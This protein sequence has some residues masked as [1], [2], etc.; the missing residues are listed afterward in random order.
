MIESLEGYRRC[1]NHIKQFV[2]GRKHNLVRE[3]FN[4]TGHLWLYLENIGWE[5]RY[6]IAYAIVLMLYIGVLI[7]EMES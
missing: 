7:Y 4:T 1:S 6:A 2:L 5:S 3:Q